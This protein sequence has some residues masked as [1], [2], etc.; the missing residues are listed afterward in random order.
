MQKP[1]LIITFCLIIFSCNS[2]GQTQVDTVASNK[3]FKEGADFLKMPFNLRSKDSAAFIKLNKQAI[4][5]F[6]LAYKY[7]TTNRDAWMWLPICYYDIREFEKV[8]YWSKK[9]MNFIMADSRL[10]SDSV[11]L[12]ET[13]EHIGL[14]LLN[15][16]E[17]EQAKTQ[18]QSALR[19]YKSYDTG[20]GLL[21][22]EVKNIGVSIYGKRDQKQIAK[23]QRK[24][25]NPCNYSILVYQYALK[26]YQDYYQFILPHDKEV[27]KKMREDC[28]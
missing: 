12:G 14:S 26:L 13:Y 28:K 7:D 3:A 1:F 25:I 8:M 6:E 21:I 27:L 17:L 4:E 18:F 5:K 9:D 20:A 24:S 10:K 19:L 11:L 16:G 23:L 15:L 22:D 2:K